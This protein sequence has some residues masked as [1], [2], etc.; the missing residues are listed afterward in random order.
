MLK[1]SFTLAD[2]KIFAKLSGDFNPVH[3]DPIVARRSLFGQ[4]IVHGIHLLLWSLDNCVATETEPLELRSLKVDFQ[5]SVAINTIATYQ[6][7]KEEKD[8]VRIKLDT[9]G[10]KVASVKAV[11]APRG[12]ARSVM[13]PFGRPNSRDPRI[14][15]AGKAANVSGNLMLCL[16]TNLATHLFPNALRILPPMQVAELLATTRLVGMEC[17]GLHSIYSGLDITF[18]GEVNPAPVMNYEVI[19]YDDRY[20]LLLMRVLSS[21]MRGTIRAFLRPVPQ[22]QVSFTDL[23]QVNATEF[24]RQHALI[25]GGSRGLGEVTAKLLAAGGAELK[26]TYYQGADDAHRIVDEIASG[27]GIAECF[28]IDVLNPV[29]DLPDHLGDKWVPSHLYYFATPFISAATKRTFSPELFQKFCD[30]YVTG[31]LNIVK[32]IQSLG[33][34]LQKIFY[35]STV[36]V[37]ELPLNMGEYAAAKMAGETLCAFLEKAYPGIKIIKPRLPKLATDQ[38]RGLLPVKNQDPVPILLEELRRFR[39]A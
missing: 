39:D 2:Q 25:I 24:A 27:G 29:Q 35:P 11:L 30:Y 14:L 15:C 34:G 19:D 16:D 22:E 8:V 9:E 38:T 32:E 6:H 23:Q 37:D 13:V 18:A 36:F 12:K 17:P 26:I 28:P 10:K 5:G 21:R 33:P 20:S 3:I 31:F 4:P 1:R 7:T